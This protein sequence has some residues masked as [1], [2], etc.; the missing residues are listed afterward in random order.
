V[1]N[2]DFGFDDVKAL[3]PKVTALAAGGEG[4]ALA[5]LT[6]AAAAAAEL[7]DTLCGK[8]SLGTSPGVVITGGVALDSTFQP[9]LLHA[10]RRT[11]PG[12]KLVIPDLPPA[13][14][15]A[16]R[17]AALAGIPAGEPFL[18]NL[19]NTLPH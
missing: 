1:H 13:A 7:V 18:R 10:L 5:I 4:A 2:T 16:I 15:A 8:L 17:A 3:A 12:A 11:R 9:L 19:R 14:G 6:N